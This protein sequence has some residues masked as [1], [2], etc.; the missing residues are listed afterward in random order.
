MTKR[1]YSGAKPGGGSMGEAAKLKRIELEKGGKLPFTPT[2]RYRRIMKKKME[3]TQNASNKVSTF[4]MPGAKPVKKQQS[5]KT[6]EAMRMIAQRKAFKEEKELRNMVVV[7]AGSVGDAGRVDKKGFVYDV[8]NN[9]TL[10]IDMKTGQI[11]SMGGW[12]VGKY[13]SRK[14]ARSHGIMN[15]ALKK[16]GAFFIQQK[17]LKMLEEAELAY[18]AQHKGTIWG[19]GSTGGAASQQFMDQHFGEERDLYGR[20]QNDHLNHRTGTNGSAWG[21]MS[22]NAHGTYVDNVWGGMVDNVWGTA[23]SNVWGGLG[24][25][26]WSSGGGG[27]I[28]GG[29]GSRRGG[30]W[31]GGGGSAWGSGRINWANRGHKIFGSGKEG[32][33]NFLAKLTNFLSSTKLSRMFR[34][35]RSSGRVGRSR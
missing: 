35:A 22:N 31:G 28:W 30:S 5:K 15:D 16:H 26:A 33:R 32:Q 21:A 25:S 23:D 20:T 7:K 17:K 8:G 3:E 19:G 1:F 4:Q 29:G 9:R 13:N 2:E 14:R 6:Q 18:Q 34:A 24:G 10:K 12:T 11:K 27:G